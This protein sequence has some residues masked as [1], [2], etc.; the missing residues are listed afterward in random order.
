[1]SGLVCIGQIV[2]AQGIQG[3]V[4]VKSFTADPPDVAAYGP[5]TDETGRQFRLKVAS[6]AK[7]VVICRIDGVNDRNAAEA[8]KGTRLHVAREMLPEPEEDDEFYH[9]DLIGLAV[10]LRDGTVLG[11]VRAVFDFGA[12]DMLELAG[13]GGET[14]LLPFTR[15]AVPV[16]DIKAGRLIAE[17]PEETEVP[18]G[19]AP[20]TR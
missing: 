12:G 5:V 20:E 7:G 9:A 1:M 13:P 8:L 11:K 10:E 3:A 4:R 15:A 6:Q 2:G 14:R 17:P 16:V 19:D 18:P